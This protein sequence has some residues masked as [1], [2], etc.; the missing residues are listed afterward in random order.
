[1]FTN[2]RYILDIEWYSMAQAFSKRDHADFKLGVVDIEYTQ[3]IPASKQL[4]RDH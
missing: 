3:Y 2:T 4:Y 1:M